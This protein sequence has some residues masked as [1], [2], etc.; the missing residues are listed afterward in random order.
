M[1][2]L[3]RIYLLRYATNSC[4]IRT[5]LALRQSKFIFEQLTNKKKNEQP[6]NT[7]QGISAVYA[8]GRECQSP[9]DHAW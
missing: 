6:K 2:I 3:V 5:T 9:G 4:L 1:R 8:T 7:Y